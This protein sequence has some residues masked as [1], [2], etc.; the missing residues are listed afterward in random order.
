MHKYL[1]NCHFYRNTVDGVAVAAEK[2][3]YNTALAKLRA[4]GVNKS[5]YKGPND[6]LLL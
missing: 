6:E 4:Q 3:L 1:K 2:E 5:I